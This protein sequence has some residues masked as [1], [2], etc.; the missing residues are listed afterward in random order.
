MQITARRMYYTL[1][2]GSTEYVTTATSGTPSAWLYAVGNVNFTTNASQTGWIVSGN[3][4]IKAA[5]EV[6]ISA[7]HNYNAY[8]YIYEGSTLIGSTSAYVNEKMWSSGGTTTATVDF[9]NKEIIPNKRSTNN[10]K[11]KLVV[12][13]TDFTASGITPSGQKGIGYVNM[14][15]AIKR[16]ESDL[17]DA[18]VS[19]LPPLLSPPTISELINSNNFHVNID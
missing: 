8:I 12:D 19:D 15:G 5:Y 6:Y 1:N 9:T 3:V 4:Q 16:S 18:S 17:I 7:S 14:N 11:V 2:G 10:L 13:F